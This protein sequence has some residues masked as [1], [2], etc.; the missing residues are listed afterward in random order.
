MFK[1]LFHRIACVFLWLACVPA[2]VSGLS[3]AHY[4]YGYFSSIHILTVDPKEHAI[5]PVKASGENIQR[6]SVASLASCYGALAAVN[7][8]FWKLNGTP[9][10]ALKINH[11]WYGTPVKPRGAIGW[12]LKDQRVLI[13]RIVTNYSLTECADESRIEVI[14]ASN[15]PLTS[16]EEWKELEHIVGGT[17]V[18]V[19]RGNVLKDYRSEQTL[20]SFL[21][22]KHPRTA[23][24]IRGNG[25]WVF[26]VVDGRFYGYLGGMAIEELAKF[27]HELGCIEALNLDGGSSSTM[28]L[29]GRVVNEPCG[30]LQEKDKR[31]E[32]V[33]DAI[34]I[35]PTQRSP[36]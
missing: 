3:Y 4:S 36:F 16:P 10:G 8:G 20:E 30:T 32:A 6:E 33:S 13:D 18:L 7:G 2:Y 5:I 14:P 15:P 1:R 28:V 11:H 17:P 21:S 31:V 27:M 22:N 24:G 25:E 9:A 35:F 29:E 19:S 34:L 12:S 23:V 26:V